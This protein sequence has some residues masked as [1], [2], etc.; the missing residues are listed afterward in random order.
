MPTH[1]DY[2]AVR[3]GQEQLAQRAERVRQEREGLGPVRAFRERRFAGP[4]FA[5]LRPRDPAEAPASTR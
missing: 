1:L 3:Q 2:V 5:R 4:L